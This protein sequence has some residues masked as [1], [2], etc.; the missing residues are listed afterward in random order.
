MARSSKYPSTADNKQSN[1]SRPWILVAAYDVSTGAT[2]EGYVAFNILQRLTE[3][4]R[5]ILVTRRNNRDRLLVDPA[6]FRPSC[7]RGCS[8]CGRGGQQP[9]GR[10]AEQRL[11]EC[12]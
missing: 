1:K 5:V 7:F 6:G 2:S 8:I 3:N 11:T 4:H 10:A 9:A 12:R